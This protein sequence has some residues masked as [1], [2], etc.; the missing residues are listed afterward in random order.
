MT[1]WK[2]VH[3]N[4]MESHK[5]NWKIIRK[6]GSIQ[7]NFNPLNIHIHENTLFL[8]QHLTLDKPHLHFISNIR[9]C[10]SSDLSFILM[11]L[12]HT[13]NTEMKMREHHTS[14]NIQ[15]EECHYITAGSTLGCIIRLFN[16]G[17]YSLDSSS[18][19]D[20]MKESEKEDEE[21]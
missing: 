20:T 6:I 8:L 13:T 16:N 12:S 4:S 14:G 19:V 9:N 21:Q 5:K 2:S 10:T 3:S 11:Y 18:R 17:Y 1:N 7:A 15:Q